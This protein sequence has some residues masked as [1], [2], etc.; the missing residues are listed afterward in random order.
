MI[1]QFLQPRWY[2]L[3]RNENQRQPEW[4]ELTLNLL[5]MLPASEKQPTLKENTQALRETLEVLLLPIMS[6]SGP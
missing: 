4:P 6:L 1:K 2:A 3:L 5:C